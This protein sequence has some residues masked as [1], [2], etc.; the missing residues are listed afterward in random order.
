[1][2]HPGL[3]PLGV[4]AGTRGISDAE[5]LGDVV[6]HLGRRIER[7]GQEGADEPDGHGLEGE[8]ETVVVTATAGDPGL[9]RVIEVEVSLQLYPRRR[10]GVAAVRSGLL[11]TEE[12]NGHECA[13]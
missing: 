12:L 9:I 1:V 13:R 4:P 10:A 3:L 5:L 6:Q 7:I 2:L 11:I 8:P